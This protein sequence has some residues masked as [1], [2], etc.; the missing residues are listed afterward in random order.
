MNKILLLGDSI[1]YGAKGINGYGYYVQQMFKGQAEICLP[2]D[3]C[4]DIRYLFTYADELIPKSE[5][6]FDLIHWNSGLWDVLHFVGNPKPY[7]SIEIYGQY[8]ERFFD[9]LKHRYPLSRV[10]FATT[11]PISEHLQRT[12]SYR[13]NSEIVEYNGVAQ[14][15]LQSKVDAFDDLYSFAKGIGDEYRAGDGLHFSE[16]GAQ[17][18]ADT[19]YHF[20]CTQL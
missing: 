16:E 5:V 20:L 13:R 17:L 14:S 19:V 4:Q 10:Y 3:N 1:M 15:I 9:L 12:K 11:T 6:A 2:T 8:I 18:L 7:T